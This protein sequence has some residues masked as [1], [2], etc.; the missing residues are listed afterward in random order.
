M[1]AG[2]EMIGELQTFV[3]N[4]TIEADSV[5]ITTLSVYSKINNGYAEI[6]FF[7]KKITG[8]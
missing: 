2:Q 8:N 3:F 7:G 4:E 6:A 5:N 1:L